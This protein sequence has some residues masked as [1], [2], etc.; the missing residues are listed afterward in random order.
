MDGTGTIV[1]NDLNSKRLRALMSNIY[2]LGVTNCIVTNYDGMRFPITDF[3]F[4]GALVDVPCSA[5]GNLRKSP[6]VR[7]RTSVRYSKRLSGIQRALLLRAIDSV[8]AGGVI[9]Y[10]TCTFAPEENEM[11]V[12]YA[13]QQRDVHIEP[14]EI[15]APH[16]YGLTEW[17]GV[18]FHH[19]MQYAV[20]IY[21]HHFNSGGGF[22]ARLRKLSES[23][24]DTP[25][26][27]N[28][29][30]TKM[31]LADE[32]TVNALLNYLQERFGVGRD[33]FDGFEFI[34]C[35][36]SIW[37]TNAD[38]SYFD[39]LEKGAS[40]GLRLA[41]MMDGR[42]KPASYALM[43]LQTHIKSSIIN[44][45][46][47][48]LAQLLLGQP[49]K[50]TAD[51]AKGYVAIAFEGNIIGCGFYT[52]DELRYEMPKGRRAELLDVLYCERRLAETK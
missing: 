25:I 17:E 44:V 47:D 34:Q 3:K 33:V 16:S 24:S 13:L 6:R 38:L 2:K 21:P 9:V 23:G 19:D 48:K 37:V 27:L 43:W 45:S 1:A 36:D 5:E 42:F 11:I 49:V 31:Q 20:R 41:R 46:L 35:A 51:L 18:S 26:A 10:S 8:K 7:F 14:I 32:H 52:G 40:I 50:L 28:R 12:Q 39:A 29:A 30:R 15:D 22:V 4:D